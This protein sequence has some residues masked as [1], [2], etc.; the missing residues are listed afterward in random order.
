MEVVVV[1]SASVGA[2]LVADAGAEL[3]RAAPAAVLGVATGSSPEPVYDELA[4]RSAAGQLDLSGISAFLLDEYLGLRADDAAS[5]RQ[6]IK[7]QVVSRLG[8][9]ER[10]VH[11]LDPMTTDPVRTCADYEA[12]LAAAGGGDLELLGECS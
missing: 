9:D 4:R 8:L 5:Y 11:S 7:R 2:R 6:V 3:A 10:R 12:A 1:P